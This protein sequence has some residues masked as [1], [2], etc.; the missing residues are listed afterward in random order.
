M[1]KRI[2]VCP[3]CMGDFTREDVEK[4][5]GRNSKAAL[6]GYCSMNCYNESLPKRKISI[7]DI[8]EN[9]L[10]DKLLKLK[11]ELIS[12][13]RTEMKHLKEEILDIIEKK[14]GQYG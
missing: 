13:Q 12:I 6:L 4:Y 1:D 7:E 10:D 5:H 11:C 8:D 2:R 9:N 14:W 3:Q